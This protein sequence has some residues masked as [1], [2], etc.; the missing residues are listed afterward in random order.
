MAE[1]FR[2]H[3]IKNR[4]TIL[5]GFGIGALATIVALMLFFAGLT[6]GERHFGVFADRRFTGGFALRYG[7]GAVGTIDSLGNNTIVIKERSGEME[8]VLVDNNTVIRK[9]NSA[10]K[11]SDLKKNDQIIIIG[12][13]ESQEEAVKARIIRV[14]QATL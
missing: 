3:L 7:H 13:P 6:L 10:I 8:T 5:L 11:F 1:D 4:R 12:Q 14:I 2:K 9:G